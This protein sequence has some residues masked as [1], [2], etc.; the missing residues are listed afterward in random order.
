MSFVEFTGEVF[1]NDFVDKGRFTRT[2]YAGNGT[3]C[4]EG[5]VNIN[6]F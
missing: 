6:I 2:G 5:D 4:A 3:E 1:I